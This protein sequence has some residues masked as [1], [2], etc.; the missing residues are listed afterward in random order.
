VFDVH[1]D[2]TVAQLKLM[3]PNQPK[4][5]IVLFSTLLHVGRVIMQL[6]D[7]FVTDGTETGQC[8]YLQL[9]DTLLSGTVLTVC[10]SYPELSNRD[11]NL[12]YDTA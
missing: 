4:I 7:R 9:E 10:K 6:R 12:I 5:V 11:Q 1:R 3:P 8:A 2:V